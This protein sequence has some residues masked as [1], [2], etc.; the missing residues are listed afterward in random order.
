[1]MHRVAKECRVSI[2]FHKNFANVHEPSRTLTTILHVS[3]I[4]E[5][6]MNIN[7]LV[8]IPSIE[9]CRMYAYIYA[10]FAIT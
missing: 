3:Q 9:P 1:M 4:N 10:I 8:I 5:N 6:T 7:L 2:Q